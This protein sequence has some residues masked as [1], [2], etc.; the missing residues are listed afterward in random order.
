MN[1]SISNE[2]LK[3][4]ELQDPFGRDCI[5]DSHGEVIVY[6]KRGIPCKR[7]LDLELVNIE[8]VCVEIIVK[9]KKLLKWT[10]YRPPNASPVVLSDIKNSIGFATN[11]GVEDIVVTGDLNLNMLN[12]HSQMKITDLCQTYNLTQLINDPTHYT[13]TSFSI[14]D[15]VLV[16]NS[17]SVELSG[18]SEPFLSQGVRH[19][20]PVFVIF[21]FKKPQLK[22]FLRDLWLYNQG[23]F[24]MFQPFVTGFNWDSIKSGDVNQYAFNFTDKLINFA[25]DCIPHKQVRIRTQ[26]L[27]WI[28]GTICKLMKKRIRLY[29]MHKRNETVKNINL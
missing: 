10:F 27:M 17:H 1:N 7:R 6:V 5:G 22:S 9:N 29:K 24:N 28:N 18:V 14:I 13:E 26:D 12:Q 11:T 20:C 3:F 21:T 4:N 16:S 19:H 23:D 8:C 2:D 15:L 25:Q